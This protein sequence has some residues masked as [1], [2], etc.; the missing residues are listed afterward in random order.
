MN[1]DKEILLKEYELNISD[2]DRKEKMAIDTDHSIDGYWIICF[3]SYLC[4]DS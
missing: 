4:T 1:I 2:H 3:C